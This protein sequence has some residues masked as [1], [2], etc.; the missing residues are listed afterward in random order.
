MTVILLGLLEENDEEPGF[1]TLVLLTLP[2]A[3]GEDFAM[4]GVLASDLCDDS[5]GF[6]GGVFDVAAAGLLLLDCGRAGALVAAVDEDDGV[7]G[8]A[9]GFLEG[10]CLGVCLSGLVPG[11]EAGPSM[12][13]KDMVGAGLPSSSPD[14]KRRSTD[15]NLWLCTDTNFEGVSEPSSLWSMAAAVAAAFF[16]SSTT[17]SCLLRAGDGMPPPRLRFVTCANDATTHTTTLS[18]TPHCPT[19]SAQTLHF[20][21][22]MDLCKMYS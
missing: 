3:I 18:T 14:M 10:A 19:Q 2:P 9:S 21:L 16:L 6:C 17:V 13:W 8:P 15:M 12:R 5:L 20:Q 1:F 22:T 11:L 7:L 4:P